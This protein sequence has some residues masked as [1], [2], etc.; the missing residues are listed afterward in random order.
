LSS[1]LIGCSTD[2]CRSCGVL[3]NTSVQNNHREHKS[4][5]VHIFHIWLF[6]RL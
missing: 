1:A 3:W 5:V 2:L 4:G 6:R